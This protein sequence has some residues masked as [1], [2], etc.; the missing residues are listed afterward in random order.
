MNQ[1]GLVM[2]CLQVKD[3]QALPPSQIVKTQ[4]HERHVNQMHSTRS[5]LVFFRLGTGSK[6]AS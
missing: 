4:Y 1:L 3:F 5:P 6:A 2:N